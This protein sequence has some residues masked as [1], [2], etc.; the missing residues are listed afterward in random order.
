MANPFT[1]S[2][3]PLLLLAT[4]LWFRAK[5]DILPVI[6][7]MSVF[8]AASVL[9]VNLGGSILGIGPSYLLLSVAATKIFRR[10]Q[11]GVCV[12]RPLTSTTALIVA[13]TVYAAISAFA[14]P[15]VFQGVLF[16]NP[17]FGSLVPLEW[18]A[19]FL[20]QLIYLLGSV[21][22][23]WM[24][25][26]KATAAEL[27]KA[28]NWYVGGTVLAAGVAIY[29]FVAMKTGLPFP[30]EILHTNPSYGIFHAYELDGLP[31]MNGTFTEA[32]TAAFFLATS[33][34]LSIWKVLTGPVT[35]GAVAVNVMIF[36][37]LFLTISTTGYICLIFIVCVALW[38]YISKWRGNACDRSAKLLL[39]VPV[40]AIVGFVLVNP[41][42]QEFI[43]QLLHSSLLDKPQTLSFQ[44]R[45]QWNSDAYST[46]THTYWLG[47]G[48][49]VCRA[50]SIFPTLLG[51]VGIP[52]VLLLGL[53]ALRPFLS[54]L[55]RTEQRLHGAVLSSLAT[56]LIALLVS[57]PELTAQIIWLLWA[58]DSRLAAAKR[59]TVVRLFAYDSQE[60]SGASVYAA[61]QFH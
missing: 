17:K 27:S 26:Y 61:P 40:I 29:Q 12:G 16:T 54:L 36:A 23:Y 31:R 25:A 7:F 57:G 50:S 14:G 3:A 11:K 2:T 28:L 8:Q 35:V 45:T 53:C 49:G 10:N 24:A 43:S 42:G 38:L 15:A 34:A 41:T 46:A 30:S 6:M 48:W 32:A 51:N 39:S 37:G 58:I 9:N 44:E 22:L 1:L 5:G 59:P 55:N 4:Y 33:L 13:F 20:P 47:A 21:S 60:H 56:A 19:G 18:S 52:G